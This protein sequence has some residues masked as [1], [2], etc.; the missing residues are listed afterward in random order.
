MN[1]LGVAA[2]ALVICA[3]AVLIR[4]YK[5]EYSMVIS[6]LAGIVILFAV[7]SGVLPVLDRLREYA[8]HAGVSGEYLDVLIKAIGICYL[9]QFSADSCRDAGESSLAGK[10]EL[11]GKIAILISALPLLDSVISMAVNLIER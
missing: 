9:T 2:A 7:C 8:E 10:V 4:Q 3:I 1:V 6:L 11:A 5:P